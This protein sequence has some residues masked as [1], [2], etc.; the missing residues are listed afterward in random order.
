MTIT[1]TLADVAALSLNAVRTLENH[2]LD[3][4]CGGKQSF[5]EACLAKGLDPD[6]VLK[7][8]EGADASGGP[9]KDWQ[10]APLGEL[11][12]HIVSTHHEY[13]KLELPAIGSRMD[14]VLAVH[15]ARDPERLK[16]A[17]S[18]AAAAASARRA[19]NSTSFSSQRAT[20]PLH[21]SRIAANARRRK[22]YAKP[23]PDWGMA[24]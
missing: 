9:V 12:R 16:R 11:V 7:E 24:D 18:L 17:S 6:S 5:D 13:L 15:G 23:H 2:G 19:L 21:R 1:K 22:S 20:K 8:I 14:K 10:T 3:Y 4:C